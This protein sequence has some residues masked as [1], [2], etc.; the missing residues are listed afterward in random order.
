[1]KARGNTE[2]AHTNE[3]HLNVLKALHERQMLVRCV[4]F[5]IHLNPHTDLIQH[6]T[7]EALR[8]DT[9]TILRASRSR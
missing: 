8:L 9:T 2:K 7:G 4:K 6:K 5:I 1:M 3:T